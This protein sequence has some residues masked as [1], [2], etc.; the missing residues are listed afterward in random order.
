MNATARILVDTPDIVAIQYADT[1]LKQV[2][3][4]LFTTTT[5]ARELVLY[6]AV[7]EN[8]T[9]QLDGAEVSGKDLAE[10][11]IRIEDLKKNSCRVLELTQK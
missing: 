1:A 4:H 11:G 6:P 7:N 3:L 5:H 2:V 8:A 10:N 9:Y